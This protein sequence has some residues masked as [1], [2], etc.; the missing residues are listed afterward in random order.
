[1]R[2]DKA[3]NNAAEIQA[4]TKAVTTAGANAVSKLKIKTDSQFVINCVTKWMS[5]WKR[6]GWKTA[7][8]HEV[9][10]KADLMI[11][12][13]AMEDFGRKDLFLSTWLGTHA[14]TMSRDVLDIHRDRADF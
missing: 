2:G 5:G 11:L 13:K 1:M 10:N 9:I 8:G 7:A 12:D 6:K 4:V 3:T 14:S